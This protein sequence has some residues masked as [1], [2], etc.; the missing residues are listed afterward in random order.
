MGLMEN[1]VDPSKQTLGK[2]LDALADV[3]LTDLRQSLILLE[4]VLIEAI[5]GC[6]KQRYIGALCQTVAGARCGK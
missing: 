6:A 5:A 3:V 4:V 2:L 1:T